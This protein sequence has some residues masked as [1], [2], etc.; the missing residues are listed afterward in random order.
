[1]STSS[2]YQPPARSPQPANRWTL[3]LVFVVT[4]C[5]VYQW[6]KTAFLRSQHIPPATALA[7]IH[8]R[9]GWTVDEVATPDPAS[10]DSENNLTAEQL[11]RL[12]TQIVSPQNIRRALDRLALSA[13]RTAEARYDRPLPK[14]DPHSLRVAAAEDPESQDTEIVIA[15]EHSDPSFATAL[16]N[17][18]AQGYADATQTAWTEAVGRLLTQTRD[19]VAEA[20]EKRLALQSVADDFWQTE[21]KPSEDQLRAATDHEQ[22][23]ARQHGQSSSSRRDPSIQPLAT[24]TIE[25]PDWAD[26]HEQIVTLRGER[27]LMLVQRTANHPMVQELDAEIVLLQ[28]RLKGI[29]KTIPNPVAAT[30]TETSPVVASDGSGGLDTGGLDTGGLDTGG[31]DTGGLDT[32]NLDTA[33]LDTTD[34]DSAK[35]SREALAAAHAEKLREHRQ[36]QEAAEQATERYQIALAEL[37]RAK[38]FASEVPQLTVVSAEAVELPPPVEPGRWLLLASIA[39]GVLAT[40]GTSMVSSGTSMRR[41]VFSIDE[42][43]IDAAVPVVGVIPAAESDGSTA[44]SARRWHHQ[45]RGRLAAGLLLWSFCGMLTWRLIV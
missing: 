30:E 22:P 1:M 13:K 9:G 18:L 33:E 28:R 14:V 40:A 45:R 19:A 29:P 24:P 39:A 5:L 35:P 32:G 8:Q 2:N 23:L 31:L 42:L 7:T 36:L 11:E 10:L 44:M 4:S 16:V 6:G 43:E 34:L 37:R 38:Q 12:T 21:V 3:L 20:D 26:L 25:N 27:K 41:P 17:Q 15:F